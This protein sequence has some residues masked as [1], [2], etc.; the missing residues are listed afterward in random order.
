MPSKRAEL[1]EQIL[2][3]CCSCQRTHTAH[4]VHVLP[5]EEIDSLDVPYDMDVAG[6]YAMDAHMMSGD[7]GPWCEGANTAPQ[8]IIPPERR[9]AIKTAVAPFL[10]A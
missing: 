7:S 8:A 3:V 5:A 2:G 1:P 4:R 10:R 6:R 9:I